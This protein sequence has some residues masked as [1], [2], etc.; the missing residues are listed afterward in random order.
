[1]DFNIYCWLEC[2]EIGRCVIV[3]GFVNGMFVLES[4]RI[5]LYIKIQGKVLLVYVDFFFFRNFFEEVMWYKVK[6]NIFEL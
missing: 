6:D 1:M 5:I 3:E 4:N 2:G